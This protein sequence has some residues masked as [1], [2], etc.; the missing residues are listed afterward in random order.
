[1]LPEAL[2]SGW[3][4]ETVESSV[5]LISSPLLSSPLLS[6][7]LLSSPLRCPI[8]SPGLPSMRQWGTWWAAQA[9]AQCPS[10]RRSCWEPLEV[11][12]LLYFYLKPFFGHE[13]RRM[14]TELF[15]YYL[16]PWTTQQV[17]LRSDAFTATQKSLEFSG[18]GGCSRQRQDLTYSFS[19]QDHFFFYRNLGPYH[20]KLLYLVILSLHLRRCLLHFK[21]FVFHLFFP[22]R[23]RNV[24]NIHSLVVNPPENLLLCSHMGSFGHYPEVLLEGSRKK[25]WASDLP[26]LDLTHSP[27]RQCETVG[28]VQCM[29][30]SLLWGCSLA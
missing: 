22:S 11:R 19:C 30:K 2:P 18:E 26:S 1:M 8:P 15:F 17:I 24:I 3:K 16:S 25:S 29:W 9:R 21:I 4:K 7:P 5:W 13:L 6:S 28:A 10:T 27:S 12:A 14:S 23:V 20:Q